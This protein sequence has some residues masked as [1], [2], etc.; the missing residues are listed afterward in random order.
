MEDDNPPE[1]R[2]Y[3][4]D[5]LGR[6]LRGHRTPTGVKV[7][8][9]PR[10]IAIAKLLGDYRFLR[11]S[12]IWALL[13][14]D[15][16]GGSYRKFQKRLTTLFHETDTPYGNAFLDW[17][18]QQDAYH[19]ARYTSG[20]FATGKGAEKCLGKHEIAASP[21]DFLRQTHPSADG[22]FPHSLLICDTIASIEVGLA[23]KPDIRLITWGEI[24]AK[25]PVKSRAFPVT[26]SYQFARKKRWESI[27]FKLIPD[28]LFGI[29]YTQSEGAKKYVF[30]ALEAECKN[31]VDP[32]NLEQT[33]WLKK[34][35]G[36]RYILKHRLYHKRLGLPHLYIL[37]TTPTQARIDTM[38]QI[39][40]DNTDQRG[41]TPFFFHPMP[42][43]SYR[44]PQMK[45][46]PVPN[47]FASPLQ[48]AG[49]PIIR[50]DE[51]G[52]G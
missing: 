4:R 38:K 51:L 50:L 37:T 40:M 8:E 29:E 30:F 10:D 33:S 31:R 48:R 36:Y 17:P 24:F 43:L 34:Y 35:L 32:T 26:I 49:H 7:R 19:N 2:R 27:S 14:K 39:I 21:R 9:Q 45:S 15:V 46:P 5:P 20:I 42:V 16:R 1:P 13:P 25:A 11:S 41:S 12:M 22:K 18:E 52:S 28:G 6:R 3:L 44:Y 23:G 47:L